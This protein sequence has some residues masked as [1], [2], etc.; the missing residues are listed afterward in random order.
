LVPQVGY[1]ELPLRDYE[2]GLRAVEE[3]LQ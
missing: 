3:A 2:A 1:V